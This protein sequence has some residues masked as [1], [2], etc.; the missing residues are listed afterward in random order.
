MTIPNFFNYHIVADNQKIGEIQAPCKKVAQ[1]AWES[2][3][4]SFMYPNVKIKFRGINFKK[5][6]N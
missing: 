1:I 5:K 4:L 6:G 3:D 2:F